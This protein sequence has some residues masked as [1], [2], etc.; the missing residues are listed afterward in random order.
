MKMTTALLFAALALGIPLRAAAALGG[1]LNSIQADQAQFHGTAR[2]TKMITYSVH[3]IHAANGVILKEYVSPA[4][5]VFGVSWRGPVNPDMRQ[6][7]GSF[8]EQYLQA[9]HAQTVVR[10]RPFVISQPG[11]VVHMSGTMRAHFGRAYVPGLVPSL[12]QPES[13]R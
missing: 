8:Y 6:I 11:L 9:S 4:G 7:L 3:E 13:I 12:V 10:G 5:Q 1:D 2:I